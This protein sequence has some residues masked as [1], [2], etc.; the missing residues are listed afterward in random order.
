[1]LFS[2]VEAV[3]HCLRMSGGFLVDIVSWGMGVLEKQDGTIVG[4]SWPP[5]FQPSLRSIEYVKCTPPLQRTQLKWALLKTLWI[6]FK[7]FT[8]P[9]VL[10]HPSC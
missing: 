6:S 1:M 3:L 4:V 8:R 2:V 5:P 7:W 9:F 10:L